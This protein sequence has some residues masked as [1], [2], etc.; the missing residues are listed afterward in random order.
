M[1]RQTFDVSNRFSEMGRFHEGVLTKE[2]EKNCIG[3]VIF[4][5]DATVSSLD[6]PIEQFM[7][8]ELERIS[9]RPVS[10]FAYLQIRLDKDMIPKLY[11]EQRTEQYLRYIEDNLTAGPIN[12]VLFV[13]KDAPQELN[14]LKG[15]VRTGSG[16]RGK[17]AMTEAIPG[18]KLELWKNGMLNEEETRKIGIELFAKSLI[19]VPDDKED[20]KRV[21]DLLY[22]KKEVSDL[23]SAVPL[24]ARWYQ[25][26]NQE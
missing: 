22:P 23:I 2:E 14:R 16:V 9:G 12:L 11:P 17:F 25:N 24:F 18:E 13:T 8:E 3:I 6:I 21:I 5:P 1:E 19:H 20:T 7:K 4:K 10:T 26:N 15:S